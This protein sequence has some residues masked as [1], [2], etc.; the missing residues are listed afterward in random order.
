[1]KLAVI[2]PSSNARNLERCLANLRLAER[3][4]PVVVVSDGL[5]FGALAAMQYP[6]VTVAPGVKPFVFA[7]NVNI[8]IREAAE[9]HSPDGFIILNDDALVNTPGGFTALGEEAEARPEYGIISAVT[10]SAGNPNQY[11]RGSGFRDEPRVLCFVCVLVTAAALRCV[12]LL[13]E[14]FTAYGWEDNDLCRRVLEYGMKLGISESCFV[15][16]LSLVSTFRGD[17]RAARDISQ[18]AAIYRAKWG[19]LA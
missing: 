1:M 4:M 3:E 7:R 19:D 10:N 17:P 9:T 6:A 8:G 5:E 14:R 2:I 18:G 16:H 11:S 15:D 13:D 12:G